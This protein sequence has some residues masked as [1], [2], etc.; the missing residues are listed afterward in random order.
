MQEN[1][2]QAK[3]LM[4]SSNRILFTTHERTDGDDLGSVLALAIAAQEMGKHVT[5]AV[6]EGVPSRLSYMPMSD[7]VLSDINHTN[8][9]LLIISGC[10][11]LGRVNN[12]NIQN[13]K[14]PKINFDHHPDNQFYAEVNV[15]DHTKSSVAELVFDFFKFCGW[16]ISHDIATNL[17]TGIVTDTGLLMHSNTQASTLE[18]A[19]ELMKSGARISQVSK[20]TFNNAD[21]I[22]LKAW[23]Q[24][25]TNSYYNPDNQVIYSVITQDQLQSLGNPEQ[26]SFEGLVETLNKVPE[27]KYAMFLKEDGDRIKGS[28]R[29]EEYKGVNV[30]QIAQ[31]LGGGGHKLAAGFSMVGKL[32]KTPDGKWEII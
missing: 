31:K 5:I 23:G 11:H 3:Q 6:T 21:P 26:A 17:L 13:L 14:I 9:D 7:E 18:A 25:L 30:Q 28:L 1:F 15:V 10:S 24:A 32:A 2:L 20:H 16:E 19:S 27:A 12:P 22:Q 29:S 8:F 4:E